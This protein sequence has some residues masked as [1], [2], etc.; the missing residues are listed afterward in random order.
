[1]KIHDDNLSTKFH[2]K[3]PYLNRLRKKLDMELRYTSNLSAMRNKAAC[4][5][6]KGDERTL[7]L[8]REL[9]LLKEKV[10]VRT[11][12]ITSL[13]RAQEKAMGVIPEED[14]LELAIKSNV[15]WSVSTHYWVNIFGGRPT[16]APKTELT[17]YKRV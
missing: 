9:D 7:P 11:N 6:A 16:T 15:I 3:L 2:A 13:L 17:F 14:Y 12:E 4:L 5:Y 8:L 10:T 1:M